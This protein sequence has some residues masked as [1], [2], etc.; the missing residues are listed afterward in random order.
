MRRAWACCA[1]GGWLLAREGARG[2]GARGARAK[3]SRAAHPPPGHALSHPIH[4]TAARESTRTQLALASSHT[5]TAPPQSAEASSAGRPLSRRSAQRRPMGCLCPASRVGRQTRRPPTPGRHRTWP[6]SGSGLGVGSGLRTG[7]G[8]RSAPGTTCASSPAL[9]SSGDAS[10]SLSLPRR[11]RGLGL[12][13]ALRGRACER[14]AC[15]GCGRTGGRVAAA[16]AAS[17]VPA[18]SL[19]CSLPAPGASR[20][21]PALRARAAQGT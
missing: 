9:A 4:P 18:G 13:G 17:L 7:P 1:C 15:S 6:R 20:S 19:C 14:A 8:S 3:A 12:R 10:G 16:R 21:R 5:R 2:Q 11:G